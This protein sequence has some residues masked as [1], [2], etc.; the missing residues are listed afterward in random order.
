MKQAWQSFYMVPKS[1]GARSVDIGNR[2]PLTTD[3]LRAD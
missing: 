1:I 2:D 3:K